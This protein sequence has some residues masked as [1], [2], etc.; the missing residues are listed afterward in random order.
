[1]LALL[2]FLESMPSQSVMTINQTK[3]LIFE[4]SNFKLA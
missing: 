2:Y 4:E 1:M 3:D